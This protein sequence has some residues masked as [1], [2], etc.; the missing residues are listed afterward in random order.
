MLLRMER[1]SQ[2]AQLVARQADIAARETELEALRRKVLE[3]EGRDPIRLTMTGRRA[4]SAV[5][6]HLSHCSCFRSR[7]VHKQAGAG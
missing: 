5:S 1:D 6:P 3:L 2:A 7:Q 4:W